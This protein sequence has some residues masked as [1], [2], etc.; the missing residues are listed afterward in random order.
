MPYLRSLSLLVLAPVTLV[1]CPGAQR[2]PACGEGTYVEKHTTVSARQLRGKS[3]IE[4][5]VSTLWRGAFQELHHK[6]VGI[7]LT[8]DEITVDQLMKYGGSSYDPSTQY[9]KAREALVSKGIAV[10]YAICRRIG[11]RVR[12]TD[13]KGTFHEFIIGADPLPLSLPQCPAH[14]DYAYTV[15]LP[16][17]KTPG[18]WLSASVEGKITNDCASQL[19][20]HFKSEFAGCHMSVTLSE[21]SAPPA[22]GLTAPRTLLYPKDRLLLSPHSFVVCNFEV[23]PNKPQCLRFK[24]E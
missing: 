15:D 18:L 23:D 1:P 13:T 16:H 17:R 19:A 7:Y 2:P 24:Q 21:S 3:S 10:V 22:A 12:G 4:L 11:C 5:A 14:F 6:W 8:F 9:A 20:E